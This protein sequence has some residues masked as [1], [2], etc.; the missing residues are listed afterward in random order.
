MLALLRFLFRPDLA[1]SF[2]PG[3]RVNRMKSGGLDRWDGRVIAQTDDGVLV[4]WPRNGASWE[5][6]R[7]LCIQG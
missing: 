4:E 3:F 2:Q 6:A 7:E 1:P 5:R